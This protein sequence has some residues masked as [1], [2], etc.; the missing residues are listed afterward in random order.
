E[1]QLD[2]A[3][4][5]GPVGLPVGVVEVVDLVAGRDH[6]AV[7]GGRPLDAVALH[8]Q[9]APAVHHGRA[10]AVD[11]GPHDVLRAAH[12]DAVRELIDAAP[13][14]GAAETPGHE[15]VVVAATP[16]QHGRL[17]LTRPG[18]AREIV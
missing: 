9:R 1:R 18:E 16:E 13:F 7:P 14:A 6:V 15:Q 11:V 3:K 4:L 17:Y 10:V 8:Q 2:D 12:R 5:R